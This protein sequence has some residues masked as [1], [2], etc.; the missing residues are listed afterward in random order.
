MSES[1]AQAVVL[2]VHAKCTIESGDMRWVRDAH[3]PRKQYI[4]IDTAIANALSDILSTYVI[5]PTEDDALL[6]MKEY[7]ASSI[8][9]IAINGVVL[10]QPKSESVVRGPYYARE[11]AI[12]EAVFRAFRAAGLSV[13]E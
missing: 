5:S 2:E 1:P 8:C 7:S 9:T 4:N 12:G 13:A 11:D 6:Q 3:S 10:R